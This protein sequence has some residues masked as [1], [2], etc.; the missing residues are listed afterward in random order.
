MRHEA[1]NISSEL[2]VAFFAA[3]L[4]LL[5]LSLLLFLLF[6]LIVCLRKPPK[7]QEIQVPIKLLAQSYPLTD[8]DK[9]TD[10]FNSQNVIG[11]GRLGTVY[12]AVMATRGDDELVVVKRIHPRL[13]LSNAGFKFSSIVRS[14]YL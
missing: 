9:A 12:A 1:T 4:I 8:I 11:M 3:T 10:G 13:V 2:L 7:A 5:T 14:L 6:L